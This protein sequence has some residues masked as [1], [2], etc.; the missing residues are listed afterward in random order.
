MNES[1]RSR[2]A[3][4]PPEARKMFTALRLEVNRPR[5][6]AVIVLV[7][8][9]LLI[10]LGYGFLEND[11]KTLP[12]TQADID[13]A[14]SRFITERLEPLEATLSQTTTNVAQLHARANDQQAALRAEITTLREQL[15]QYAANDDGQ[16]A[17]EQARQHWQSTQTALTRR[18]RRLETQAAQVKE[19][20]SAS[21]SAAAQSTPD[22][23]SFQVAAVE[24][25]GDIAY[26]MGVLSASLHDAW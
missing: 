5:I 16:R 7:V 3:D 24:H 22:A 6:L 23:P 10:V 9:L 1:L 8:V 20:A 19:K 15:S 4:T 21:K 18:V 25:W 12:L 11:E 26:V 13:R 14:I 2:T 17:L